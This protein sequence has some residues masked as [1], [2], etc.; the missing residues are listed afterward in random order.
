MC[1]AV[2]Y[3][4]SGNCKITRHASSLLRQV[5]A[6]VYVWCRGTGSVIVRELYIAGNC[7][8]I[9]RTSLLLF[10]NM[11]LD[12]AKH[13]IAF[14]AK[15]KMLVAQQQTL[16]CHQIILLMTMRKTGNI[17]QWTKAR[18]WQYNQTISAFL[19]KWSKGANNYRG[20]AA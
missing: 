17:G 10:N 9:L 12:F 3:K 6:D 2:K 15:E 5:S 16:I 14:W 18:C 1:E 19:H 7:Q 13:I 11:W 8:E 20:A 4:N